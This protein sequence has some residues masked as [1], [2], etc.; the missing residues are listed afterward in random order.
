MQQLVGMTRTIATNIEQ[1]PI[2]FRK[3]CLRAVWIV[4]CIFYFILSIKMTDELQ[5]K[6]EGRRSDRSN[7]KNPITFDSICKEVILRDKLF[8]RKWPK[9][10]GHLTGEFFKE[11]LVEECRKA[12]FPVDTFEPK[13]PE[14][15][16][17]RSPIPLKPSPAIPRTTSGTV[18]L[19]S[20]RPECNLEFTGLWYVSPK[21]TIEPP[22][23]P[24][25]FRVT[26][27]RFIYLG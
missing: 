6:V 2:C 22:L 23:E 13:P 5:E 3:F 14:D 9:R 19:R 25:E 4:A 8:R 20:S 11:V 15:T 12:G 21:H 24:G 27:Q 7:E 17:K 1:T 18:G 16:I 10:Y 26:R